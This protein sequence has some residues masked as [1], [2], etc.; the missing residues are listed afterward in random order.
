M[1]PDHDTLEHAL[2]AGRADVVLLQHFEQR[3]ARHAGSHRRVAVTD[4]DRRPDQLRQVPDRVLVDRHIGQRRNPVEAVQQR[5]NDQHSEP[6]RRHGEP[7]DGEHADRMVDPGVLEQRCR[8]PE[9]DGDGDGEDRGHDRDLDRQPEPAADL[10]DD[11]PSGPHRDAEITDEDARHPVDELLPQ[12]LVEAEA[13]TLGGDGLRADLTA[14]DRKTKLDDVAGQ[15]PQQ[16]EHQH[17]DPE[18]RRDHQQEPLDRVS[19][20]GVPAPPGFLTWRPLLAPGARCKDRLAP[21]VRRKDR[22]SLVEPDVLQILVQV[23]ARRHVPALDLLPVDDDAMPPDGREGVGFVEGMLLELAQQRITLLRIERALL[24][25]VQVVELAV[26]IAAVVDARLV[27]RDVFDDLQI[28]VVD[29]VAIEIEPDLVVAAAQVGNVCAR[30]GLL[31]L[32]RDPDLAPLVDQKHADRGIWHRNVSIQ[33]LELEV[34]HAGLCEQCLR[35]GAGFVDVPAPAGILDEVVFRSREFVTGP[36]DAADMSYQ[37]DLGKRFGALPA[38]DRERQRA[39]HARVV[40]RLLLGVEGHH[41]IAHPRRLVHDD[42]VAE[43]GLE[44]VAVGR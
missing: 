33:E 16:H 19:Q 14:F 17:G 39:P 36:Q 29:G 22:R 31:M 18:Q 15:H 38:I 43:R 2:G 24:L 20:H 12:R 8:G 42:L 21:G 1:A 25:F 11:G 3:R 40:E 10:V 28:G 4:R 26:G 9:R 37:C 27:G 41:E 34:L 7:G 5:Q 32:G 30:L 6:E 23:M 44:L 13:D 35:L